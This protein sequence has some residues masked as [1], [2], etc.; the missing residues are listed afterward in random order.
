MTD[1][2]LITEM[3]KFWCGIWTLTDGI[4]L[5]NEV[6][7]GRYTLARWGEWRRGDRPVPVPVQRYCRERVI[8]NVLSEHLGISPLRISD[9]QIDSIVS[10]LEPPA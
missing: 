8:T 3:E 9:E 7:G 1:P 2:N 10:A 5:M 4:A 6:L